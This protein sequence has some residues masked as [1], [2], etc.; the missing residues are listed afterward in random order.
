[1]YNRIKH[2]KALVLTEKLISI[3]KLLVFAM[4]LMVTLLVA[5]IIFS[6][7]GGPSLFNTISEKTEKTAA[8]KVVNEVKTQP[9][10]INFWKA[11]DIT[12]LG[13]S[14]TDETIK[15]GKELIANTSKYLGPKGSVMQTTNGLNCQN[16]HLEA[17]TKVFGNNYGVVYANYPKYRARSGKEED[18]YKRVNDCMERSLDGKPL[19]ENSKEMQAIKAYIEWL[20]KEVAK[21][22]QPEGIGIY[23]LP[24][25]SRAAIPEKGRAV[26][27]AKCQSCHQANG[28]GVL[29]NEGTAYVYPPVWGKHSYN[30]GAGL[31]RIS[32]FAGFVKYNMPLGASHQMMMLTDEE[33]WDVA[34]FVNSQ[35]RPKKDISKD[36]PNIAEK[37]VDHPFGPFADGFS[38]SQH[39]YGPFEP[40]KAKLKEIKEAKASAKNL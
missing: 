32:R 15:Y 9:A 27:E 37:P 10:A 35:P 29:N 31:Y 28:E 5:F 25:L 4:V 16:C 26:Y 33:A 7:S 13:N 8:D 19:A 14:A 34:A 40:I 21:G 24:Y 30:D 18:I 12:T 11:P 3:V 6:L 36:W 17:G 20:G 39:K 38:E 2:D 23:N 22:T 1:M